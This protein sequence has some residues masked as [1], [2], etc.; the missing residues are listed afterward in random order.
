M[1]LYSGPHSMFGMKAH[2]AALEKGIEVDVIQVSFS[3]EQGYYPKH[4]EVSRVN[5]K[6]QVPILLDGDLEIFDS[7]Q[8]FEYF[9]DIKPTPNLLS[10]EP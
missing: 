8:I 5:P 9:E 7:T 2:I 3:N 10:K 1:K 4:S 6:Q